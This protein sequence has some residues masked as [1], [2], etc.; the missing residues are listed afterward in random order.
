MPNGSEQPHDALPGR[1]ALRRTRRPSEAGAGAALERLQIWA[2]VDCDAEWFSIP[3]AGI[4]LCRE[5]FEVRARP[6]QCLAVAAHE[7]LRVR[8]V[9]AVAA[10]D[11]LLAIEARCAEGGSVVVRDAFGTELLHL[12]A[13]TPKLVLAVGIGRYSVDALLPTGSSLLVDLRS[14]AKSLGM[15]VG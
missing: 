7:E 1:N 5:G 14:R 6:G 13:G 15:R 9:F 11:G 8:L 12:V 3:Q 10:A 2:G 4:G